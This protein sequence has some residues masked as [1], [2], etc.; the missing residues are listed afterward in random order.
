MGETFFALGLNENRFWG[1][2]FVPLLLKVN[3]KESFYSPD[4]TH[5]SSH[6]DSRYSTLSYTE[7]EIVKI[8]EEYSDQNLFKYFS[9]H[10][11]LKEFLNAVTQENIDNFIRPYIEKRLAR[12]FEIN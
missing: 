1:L 7:K 12:I 5:L 10:K 9:K 11:N 8:I 2:V 4:T 6:N 3:K